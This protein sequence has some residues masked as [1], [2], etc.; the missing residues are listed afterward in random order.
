MGDDG[1]DD[2][3]TSAGQGVTLPLHDIV[4]VAGDAEDDLV[5]GVVVH[6]VLVA[7]GAIGD[8]MGIVEILVGE[9][10]QDVD[11]MAAGA[12]FQEL[13]VPHRR[14]TSLGWCWVYFTTGERDFQLA[15]GCPPS[16]G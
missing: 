5:H 1:L 10:L 13:P 14:R 16:T 12:V 15:G 2:E 9:F 6:G 3:H 7:F 8:D 11:P 4:H